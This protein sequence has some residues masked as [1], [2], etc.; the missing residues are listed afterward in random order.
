MEKQPTLTK[1]TFSGYLILNWKD[2][3]MVVRKKKP[4]KLNPFEIPVNVSIDVSLPKMPD[5]TVK[6]EIEISETQVGEMFI[7]SV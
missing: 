5:I 2:N 6:G 1:K 7:E 3:S 4:T